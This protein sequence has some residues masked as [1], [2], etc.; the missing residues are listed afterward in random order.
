[1]SF[2]LAG[3]AMDAVAAMGFE[4]VG[5]AMGFAGDGMKCSIFAAGAPNR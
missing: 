1:M 5:S 3:G 2:V 4:R